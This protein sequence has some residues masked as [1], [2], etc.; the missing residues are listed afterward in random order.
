M[1]PGASNTVSEGGQNQTPIRGQYLTP[2]DTV[3]GVLAHAPVTAAGLPVVGRFIPTHRFVGFQEYA[4]V[5]GDAI[6]RLETTMPEPPFIVALSHNDAGRLAFYLPGRPRVASAASYLG[7]RRSAYDFFDDT[8]LSAD[9]LRGRT[10]VLLGSSSDVWTGAFAFETLEA[11]PDSNGA[12]LGT[13]YQ[14]PWSSR[15]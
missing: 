4:E 11:V 7:F 5:F 10:A 13:G 15:P 1:T 3:A 6:G 8:D 2:I 9:R 14:G 12:F